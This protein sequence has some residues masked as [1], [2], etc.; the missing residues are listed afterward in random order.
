M[1]TVLTGGT[2]GAKFVDGLRRVAAPEE[3]ALVV[4]TGDDSRWWG[5][6]VS[7]DVDSILYVLA[8]RL[9]RERGWGVQNDTFFCLQSMRQMGQPSWFQVGDKDLAVHLLR[10]KLLGEGKSLSEAIAEIAIR[11]GIRARVL[12]MSND[13][14]ETRVQ[15]P[16]AELSFQEYFVERRFRDEVTSV[17]FAGSQEAAP[18]PGVVTAIREAAAV[19]IAPSN[20]ITSIGP[21][22][23]VRAI[24]EALRETSAPVL[25]ISPIVRGA[26]VS[27]PA[28]ALMKAQGFE[29][30]AGGV[31]DVYADFLDLLIAD[32]QDAENANPILDK[33]IAVEFVPTLMRTGA[34]RIALAA[35]VMNLAER[36]AKTRA[37][38]QRA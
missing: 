28:S 24:R 16:G 12:P 37:G 10:T 3:L 36:A 5:L 25:A 27:G 23:A 20:P 32:E 7:P 2:G 19:L 11:M 26:A 38:A 30:S 6:H 9:S 1:I 29:V 31:A 17:R 33:G 8:G 22:L 13:S 15:T 4:N 21:I 35:S 18:A 34:D 14:V